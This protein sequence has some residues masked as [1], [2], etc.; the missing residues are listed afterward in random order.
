MHSSM[1]VHTLIAC[2]NNRKC[3]GGNGKQQKKKLKSF[4]EFL[5]DLSCS[6]QNFNALFVT[7]FFIITSKTLS[8]KGQQKKSYISR[9]LIPF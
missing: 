3:I 7:L 5:V 4:S 2:M 8:S 1:F 9:L 6:M